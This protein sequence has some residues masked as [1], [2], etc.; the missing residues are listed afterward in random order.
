MTNILLYASFLV[1]MLGGLLLLTQRKA[2]LIT[3]DPGN[4]RS[5]KAQNTRD[6]LSIITAT[7]LFAIIVSFYPTV[8]AGNTPSVTLA[9]P[10]KLSLIHI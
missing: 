8:L 9:E 7:I 6:A 1:P 3:T 2:D 4:A 10:I 5:S